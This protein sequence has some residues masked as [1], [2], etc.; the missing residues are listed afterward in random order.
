MKKSS[1][2]CGWKHTM[3]DILVLHERDVYATK[4]KVRYTTPS[5]QETKWLEFFGLGIF[6]GPSLVVKKI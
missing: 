3:N 2:A 4:V 6:D 1:L 5:K